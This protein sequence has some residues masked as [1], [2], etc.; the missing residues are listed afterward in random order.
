MGKRENLRNG[1]DLFMAYQW[2][3]AFS[4]SSLLLSMIDLIYSL[5]SGRMTF[6]SLF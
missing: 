2:L 6:N 1:S 5:F 4:Q 3:T